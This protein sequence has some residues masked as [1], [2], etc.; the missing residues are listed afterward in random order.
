MLL[1]VVI[2]AAAWAWLRRR[3]KR[4]PELCS[5][6]LED[7]DSAAEGEPSEEADEPPGTQPSEDV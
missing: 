1:V 7:L 4:A 5:H 6:P 3:P 2:A